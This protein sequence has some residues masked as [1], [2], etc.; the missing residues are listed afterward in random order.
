[1]PAEWAGQLVLVRW[2]LKR[3]MYDFKNSFFPW[4]CM[5]S[6]SKIYS[7]QKHVL[8]TPFLSKNS[9]CVVKGLFTQRKLQKKSQI[10]TLQDFLPNQWLFLFR[11][12]SGNLL[13]LS[14]IQK[15]CAQKSVRWKSSQKQ[16]RKRYLICF[17]ERHQLF[18]FI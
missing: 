18:K 1:M 9:R 3:P 2:Q 11:N 14:N 15:I 8:P 16:Y 10:Q 17:I 6:Q 12:L 4:F 5:H 13:L 7:F